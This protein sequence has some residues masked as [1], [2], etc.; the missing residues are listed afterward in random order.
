[1]TLPPPRQAKPVQ[2]EVSPDLLP[3]YANLAR[4]AHGSTEF[5]L[6]FAR[7]LPG[8]RQA[9]VGARVIMSPLAAK[10][11]LQAL[12][13]NM[14]RYE[15]TFGAVNVPSSSTLADHLFKPL[16][17]PEGPPEKDKE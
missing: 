4:I 1:M 12:T 11:L 15:N 14:A 3:V 10:L 17:P 9:Q 13:E 7:F 5:V 16:N 8:D 2:L 6:D